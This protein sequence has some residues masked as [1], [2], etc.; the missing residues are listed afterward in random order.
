MV[1]VDLMKHCVTFPSSSIFFSLHGVCSVHL[2]ECP[3]RE[4]QNK[5]LIFA[6]DW[7]NRDER[8]PV[9]H[10]TDWQLLPPMGDSL[11][12][13]QIT[14]LCKYPNMHYVENVSTT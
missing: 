11:G 4:S 6:E 10:P 1:D 7:E 8:H 14:F 3:E 5:Y 12:I 9:Q 13:I 2:M